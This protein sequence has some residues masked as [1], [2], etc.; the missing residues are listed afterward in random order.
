MNDRNRQLVEAGFRQRKMNE[1]SCR[2]CGLR[3]IVGDPDSDDCYHYCTK[4]NFR[5]DGKMSPDNFTCKYCQDR[6]G[7][8]I[9]WAFKK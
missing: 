8:L 4:L 3:K 2:H 6:L 1:D 7:P 9:D 5:F